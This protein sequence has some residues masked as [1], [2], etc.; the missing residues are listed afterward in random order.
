MYILLKIGTWHAHTRTR[1]THIRRV[2]LP[3]PQ[4][5]QQWT[6]QSS[7]GVVCSTSV[8]ALHAEQAHSVQT[9]TTDLDLVDARS[10]G[11]SEQETTAV[12]PFFP[13]QRL[14]DAAAAQDGTIYAITQNPI[15]LMTLPASQGSNSNNS[16]SGS[17]EA[18][19]PTLTA[20]DLHDFFPRYH[21][22]LRLKVASL[23]AAF[24]G[25]VA[26]VEP[27]TG[28]ILLV[29][30]A[31][32]TVQMMS[33]DGGASSSSSSSGGGGG[34]SNRSRGWGGLSRGTAAD[35]ETGYRICKELAAGGELVMYDDDDAKLLVVDMLANEVTTIALPTG[36]KI[37]NV[38]IPSR[39][40]WVVSVESSPTSGG[41]LG[42]GSG[43]GEVTMYS[44]TKASGA[45]LL[46]SVL[47]PIAV[48]GANPVME[49]ILPSA[50]SG[51]AL[52]P[53]TNGMHLISAPEG[54]A[55]S[56][57][58]LAPG[59]TVVPDGSYTVTGHLSG[60]GNRADGG[61]TIGSA[62]CSAVGCIVTAST[63]DPDAY[64]N[65]GRNGN[66]GSSSDTDGDGKGSSSSSSSRPKPP[67]ATLEVIDTTTGTMRNID[68]PST[69]VQSSAG[70]KWDGSASYAPAEVKALFSLADGR[71]VTADAAGVVR[72]WEVSAPRLAVSLAT[73]KKMIGEDSA[74][75]GQYAIEYANV[76]G[77][78]EFERFS[79]LGNSDPKHGKEDPDND[80]H[81][82]GNTWAGGT[83][84]RDTAGLGG[85]GGPYRLDKGH[86][87][88]QLSDQEKDDV[89]DHIKEAARKMGQE[90]F[91]KKLQE[92]EM[93]EY[94]HNLYSSFS[95]E[96]QQET[97]ELKVILDGL[98]AKEDERVWLRHQTEG[99]LDDSKL[100]EGITG[101][102]TIY[103]RRG[104]ADH[105]PGGPQKN[106]K[107]ITFVADVS[108]SMYRFNGHDQRLQRMLQTT[109][110]IMEAFQ[111][112]P[113]DKVVYEIVGHSG[114]SAKIP[115]VKEGSAPQNDNE[116]LKVMRE[117][118]AHSQFC[119]SGDHTLEAA[120]LAIDEIA[121]REDADER[122]V[123]ILSDANLDRYGIPPSDLGDILRSAPRAETK[124]FCIM[125]GSLG[126]QARRL[127][128]GLPQGSSFVC[129]DTAD[130]PKI[131]KQVFSAIVD[132]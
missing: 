52:K 121:A 2:Q 43:G 116:R 33:F 115:F 32:S 106:P 85:K 42:G 16:N 87:V 31:S 44:L 46:P 124:A 107:R 86:D 77:R 94:D 40:S 3:P 61:A 89:P 9:H 54:Y 130:L 88:H 120:Q 8:S 83:G 28:S 75:S 63:V 51:I 15:Q 123:V 93:S 37:K 50:L 103:K 7:E 24:P 23:E 25:C 5:L 99:D 132:P 11:F 53:A 98:E 36:G 79:G 111:D 72:T 48:Q 68:V 84:G 65:D 45:D 64:D 78:K 96:V 131:M 4:L 95:S 122:Y 69:F 82:G 128:N 21:G 59:G 19:L 81:V 27:E 80:P 30:A 13:T 38:M 129:M 20:T 41:F 125:V 92:I 112:V 56:L 10:R 47:T 49:R 70:R 105:L 114:E 58:K 66:H 12:L 127:Q 29:D 119:M 62:H 76:Q 60:Q 18:A 39:D 26:V 67:A 74:G 108:G 91:A 57:G 34:S 35:E 118:H 90:A 109:C 110:M 100:I 17:M 101:E 1:F 102:H 14:S 126:E 104:A 6:Q 55:G 71:L 117:M 73:W 22:D 113:Q 97:R